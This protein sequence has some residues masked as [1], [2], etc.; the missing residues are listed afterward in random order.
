MQEGTVLITGAAGFIG[1][2]LCERL[3]DEGLPV[4]GVDNFDDFYD[5]Q[6][7]HDNISN[8][9]K[10]KKFQLIEADIRD[11]TTMD[12]AVKGVEIIVHLAAKAG[13]RPSITEPLLYSDVNIN[14]TMV[15]LEA[16]N[17]HKVGKFIFAS[18]SSVY[19]NNEKV[20]FSEDDNVDFPISPYAATKK[21]C[22]LICHTYHHLYGIDLTCLRFFTVYGPRQRPD[23]AI[24]KF[25]KLIEQEKPIPVYG[26]GS[27]MRDFTY[28][29]DI[30]DGIIAAMNQCKGFNIYNL[31][32]SQP[33]TVNDLISAIEKALGKTAIRE[34]LPL[35][36]GDVNRTFADIT[37]AVR[38]LD[39]NPS[40]PIPEGL[41]KFVAWLR[42]EK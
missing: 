1:S 33:I 16:A 30:I 42:Q 13:V 38:E 27:M 14:G 28:I 10:N 20:P 6:I 15:L 31:G 21:A 34:Y 36:P 2:H 5:P 24:H 40:T 19:G 7:K 12:K 4:V 23:L 26:D 11:R 17:K 25:S 29:D 35:Q 37:K 41:A 8:C 39:Y 3:L 32:E 9:L 18:S 22:E